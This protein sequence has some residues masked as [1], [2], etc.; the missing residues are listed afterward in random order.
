MDYSKAFLPKLSSF[1]VV[2][3]L[4]SG[5]CYKAEIWTILLLLRF[6]FIWYLVWAKTNISDFGRKPWTIVHGLIFGSPK[7][8]LRKV[9]HLKGN[10]KRNLMALVSVA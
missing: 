6:P 9:C 10:E 3:L 2:L 4:R 7:K 1:F 5:R 8:V